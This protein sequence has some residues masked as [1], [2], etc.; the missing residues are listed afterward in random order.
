MKKNEVNSKFTFKKS[1]DFDSD[2]DDENNFRQKRKRKDFDE[3][4]QSD[5]SSSEGWNSDAS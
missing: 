4:L 1:F 2:S 5:D 3:M